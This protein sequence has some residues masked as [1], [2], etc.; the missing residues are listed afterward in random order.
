MKHEIEELVKKGC[1]IE[2]NGNSICDLRKILKYPFKT[3]TPYQVCS[4]RAKYNKETKMLE[5]DWLYG[6]LDEAIESFTKEAK[7]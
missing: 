3:D 6:D 2:K 1:V 7:I 5:G 4:N